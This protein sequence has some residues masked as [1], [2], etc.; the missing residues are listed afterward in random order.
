M[1][2]WML[3]VALPIAVSP[4]PFSVT[5]QPG[6]RPQQELTRPGSSLR[7]KGRRECETRWRLQQFRPESKVYLTLFSGA[8]LKLY[9]TLRRSRAVFRP[10]RRPTSSSSYTIITQIPSSRGRKAQRRGV[11]DEPP[12]A[13]RALCSSP[14]CVCFNFLSGGPWLLAHLGKG[15]RRS[16]RQIFQPAVI[17]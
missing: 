12:T 1:V 16:S 2:S 7:L 17:E 4:S 5:R 10:P 8:F 9:Y 3:A 11:A 15:A 14:T 13:R 6:L